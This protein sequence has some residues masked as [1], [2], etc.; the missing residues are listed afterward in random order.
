VK[1]GILAA[2]AGLALVG[3][4]G[5]D[6][7]STPAACVG[8]A[9]AYLAALESAPGEVRL[10]GET[11]ISDCIVE[12]QSGGDLAQVGEPMIAAA[13]RLNRDAQ[14]DPSGEA[15]VELGYLIGA[16]QEAAATTGGIHEDLVR[17]LDAAARFADDGAALPAAFERAFGEGYAAG[18][19]SG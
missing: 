6:E 5:D 11:P 14:A 8:D 4:G 16:V 15:T 17:R 12:A 1:R 19:A 18:Q 10:D 7:P 9:D 13:T 3:C 2:L